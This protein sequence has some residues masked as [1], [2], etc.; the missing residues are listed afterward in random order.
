MKNPPPDLARRLLGVGEQVLHTDPPPRLEDVARLVGASRA[1]LYYYFSG[2]DDLLS[3]L[4]AAHTRQGAAA[5]R[6]AVREEDPPQVRLRAMVAA[7]ADYLGH[8]PGTC[9]GLL[10]ALGGS[11]RMSEVLEAND[12]RIAAPL[13]GLLGEGRAAG[14]F[15]VESTADAANAVLGALLLAVLGRSMAGGDP[16]EPRFRERLVEQVVGGV[17]AR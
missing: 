5:V 10:G 3:Y 17:L 15:A 4:L 1:T 16:T 14:A 7:L 6:A 11:G 9:A 12:A 8:H 2:R 13:R